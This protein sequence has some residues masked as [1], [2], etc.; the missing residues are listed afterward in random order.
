VTALTQVTQIGILTRDLDRVVRTWSDKYGVG[1]WQIHDFDPSNMTDMTVAG[2]PA[3]FGMRIA[4][5]FIGEMMLEV[6]E[7]TSDGNIYAESLDRHGGADHFHHILC[8][9]DEGF[10]AS[11]DRF[12]DKGVPTMQSGHMSTGATF[13]YLDTEA[14]LGFA[15]EVAD[16]PENFS[17]PEPAAIY[18]PSAPAAP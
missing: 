13:A 14:D 12:R 1:P 17:L 7:P 16:V 2:K 4:I 15:L 9:T 18:P 11:L 5:A 10:R 8:S 6:I 3:D